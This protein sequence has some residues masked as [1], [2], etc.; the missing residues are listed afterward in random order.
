[1]D[2]ERLKLEIEEGKDATPSKQYGY[3]YGSGTSLTMPSSGSDSTIVLVYARQM[4]SSRINVF[5][6]IYKAQFHSLSHREFTDKGA[7]QVLTYNASFHSFGPAAHLN[8]ILIHPVQPLHTVV[9]SNMLKCSTRDSPD[10]QCKHE[11]LEVE[12]IC[13]Q[14]PY[15]S[16]DIA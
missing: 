1:M 3:M 6:L 12:K 13:S 14:E 2:V 5:T 15:C 4:L 11:H 8:S 7:L 16:Q 9:C 10:I